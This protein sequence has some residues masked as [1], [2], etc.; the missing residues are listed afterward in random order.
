MHMH[1]KPISIDYDESLTTAQSAFGLSRLAGEDVERKAKTMC[2]Q[3][4]LECDRKIGT[5]SGADELVEYVERSFRTYLE[6]GATMLKGVPVSKLDE[7]T[8]PPSRD[9]FNIAREVKNN[10]GA[11]I[12]SYTHKG[13]IEN[14]LEK[15]KDYIP[16]EKC[17]VVGSALKHNN[18][19]L[20]GEIDVVSKTDGY[21]GGNFYANRI[22]D[23]PLS[24]KVHEMGYKVFLV[25]A[26]DSFRRALR[27]CGIPSTNIS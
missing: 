17:E 20:T 14:F 2:A 1:S 19:Y 22:G 8:C 12:V 10:G 5:A 18:G 21:I 9:F 3:L 16:V 11:R 24:K 25:N 26:D 7:V 13:L 6:R 4:L 15:N 23:L 27:K